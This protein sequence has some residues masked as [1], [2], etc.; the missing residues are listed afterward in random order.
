MI[1]N[2]D[3]RVFMSI[4]YS[5]EKWHE[6]LQFL[7]AILW[8]DS[9]SAFSRTEKLIFLSKHRG[10]NI[11]IAFSFP[12]RREATIIDLQNEIEN[13]I[14]IN[15]SIKKLSSCDVKCFFED[16]KSNQIRYNLYNSH[17]ILKPPFQKLQHLLSTLILVFGS[18]G[19]MSNTKLLQIHHYCES[20]FIH[21]VSNCLVERQRLIEIL[22]LNK[23]N[24]TSNHEVNVEERVFY[25]LEDIELEDRLPCLSKGVIRCL[26]LEIKALNGFFDSPLILFQNLSYAFS[27]H[28]PKQ[29][30]RA[31]VS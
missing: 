11:R 27:L 8:N 7:Q 4:F 16:F 31:F 21:S 30:G 13:Y 24:N 1:A 5:Q 20:V 6:M 23:M 12:E 14:S 3:K 29:S 15:P 2:N 28:I 19:P 10:D 17:L 22:N 25:E 9:Q 26:E 18:S